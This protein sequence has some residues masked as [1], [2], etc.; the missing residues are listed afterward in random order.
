[1]KKI[2]FSAV[3]LVAFS[4]AGMANN[5]VENDITKE[6]KVEVLVRDCYDYAA[7]TAMA[8]FEALGGHHSF[9]EVLDTFDFYLDFCKSL[10]GNVGDMVVVTN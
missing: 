9:D 1:M 8:E 2:M 10:G 6:V 4:F 7:D 5:A 3:A